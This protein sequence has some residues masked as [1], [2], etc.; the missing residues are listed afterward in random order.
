MHD[1]QTKKEHM[2]HQSITYILSHLN[3]KLS[4][5]MVAQHFHYSKYHFSRLF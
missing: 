1:E 3:D 4:V 5:E 2:I